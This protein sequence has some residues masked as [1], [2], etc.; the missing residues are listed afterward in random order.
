MGDD[1]FIIEDV[2]IDNRK[3]SK[4]NDQKT[5]RSEICIKNYS[6]NVEK[7]API[8]PNSTRIGILKSKDEAKSFQTIPEKTIKSKSKNKRK[9]SKRKER[10]KVWFRMLK[11]NPLMENR[12]FQ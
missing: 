1:D 4:G 7:S 8:Y 5:F 9:V 2:E 11:E 3:I 10:G 6:N 12:K